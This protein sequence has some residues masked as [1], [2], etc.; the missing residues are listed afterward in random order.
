MENQELIKLG[1]RVMIKNEKNEWECATVENCNDATVL[2]VTDFGKIIEKSLN[3]VNGEFVK[4]MSIEVEEGSPDMA[5]MS[6]LNESTILTNLNTRYKKNEIYTYIGSILISVNP[7]K[8]IQSMYT[9]ECLASYKNKDLGD[10]PPHVFAIANECF[11]CMWKR[12]ENQCILISGESGAGKTETTKFMLRYLSSM[13]QLQQSTKKNLEP[14]EG[15]KKSIEASILESGPILE[16]L[17]NAKTVY[18]N[19]SSRFGKFI[20]LLFN[21]SGQIKGAQI[22]DYLL[23]KHRVVHQN[24]GERNYHIFYQIIRGLSEEEKEKFKLTEPENF[25][26]L[27]QSNCTSDPTLNDKKDW[28]ELDNALEVLGFK[29]GQREDFLSVLSGILY[30][31]NVEFVNAGGAQVVQIDVIEIASKLLGIEGERLEGVMKEKTIQLR[32][33]Y[34]TSPQS[35]EQAGAS[36][37]SISMALYSNLFRW[38]ISKINAKIKGPDNFHFIG[39]LDIFGFENFKVNRFEQ[40]CINFA[41]EKLQEYFNRH[42][43]S[44]EQI[45]YSREGIDWCEVEWMDNSECLDLVEK[46]LGLISLINEE[47]RFPKGTDASLLQKLH[48]QHKKNVFYVKP[49]VTGKEFGIKHYA[50]EVMYNVDGFLEKNRDTFRDDLLVLLKDSSC[51][52]IYE[53]FEK[54]RVESD[55][56]KGKGR[57]KQQPTAGG[58]FKKSLHSL[59]EQLST[60]NPFFVRCIKPNVEKLPELFKSDVVLNQLRYSGM[61]ETIRVR[62]AGFPVRRAYKD[63][64]DRYWMISTKGKVVENPENHCQEILNY[65]E[66]E[67]NLWRMGKTKAF[68]KEGIEKLLEKARGE[69]VYDAAVKVQSLIRC[70]YQ[71]KK[72]LNILKSNIVIQRIIRGFLARCMYKKVKKAVLTLQ[73]CERGRKARKLFK[74][75][76]EEKR[77]RERRRNN[78]AITIQKFTRGYAARKVFKVLLEKHRQL[79]ALK[80][81]MERERKEEAERRQKEEEEEAARLANKKEDEDLQDSSLILPEPPEF[82]LETPTEKLSDEI[83]ISEAT[84]L[85]LEEERENKIKIPPPPPVRFDSMSTKKNNVEILSENVSSSQ[86]RSSFEIKQEQQLAL[87]DLDAVIQQAETD[88]AYSTVKKSDEPG[89]TSGSLDSSTSNLRSQEQKEMERIIQLEKEIQEMHKQAE[90]RVDAVTQLQQTVPEPLIVSEITYEKPKEEEKD[91]ELMKDLGFEDFEK[92]M[93]SM[94]NEQTEQENIIEKV[95]EQDDMRSTDYHLGSSSQESDEHDGSDSYYTDS[96]FDNDSDLGSEITGSEVN[97][98]KFIPDVYFHSYIEMKGGLMNQWKR[99][100]CAISNNLFMV[101]RSKQDSLKCGWLYKKADQKERSGS[102][103][104]TLPRKNWQKKWFT[105]KSTE[106][107]YYDNDEENAKCRGAFSIKSFV[108]VSDV[109]EKENG[110]DIVMSNNKIMQVAAEN[111]EDSN[112]WYSILMKVH[113]SSDHEL[114]TMECDYANPKNALTTIEGTTIK[115]AANNPQAGKPNVFSITTSQRVYSF[116]CKMADEMHHWINL[117]NESRY[118][119]T[120]HTSDGNNSK[121]VHDSAIQQG[122]MIKVVYNKLKC[123]YQRRYF[124][125]KSNVIEYY[126]TADANSQKMGSFGLN[127]LCLVGTPDETIFKRTGKWEFTVYG[128]KHQLH[129]ASEKEEDAN[130]WSSEI[131]AVIDNTP[132][133]ITK[134]KQCLERIKCLKKDKEIDV[135]YKRHPIM[136]QTQVPLRSPLL[137]LSYE[138]VPTRDDHFTLRDEAVKFFAVL[139]SMEK[140]SYES[141]EHEAMALQDLLRVCHWSKSLQDEIFL[142]LIKQTAVFHVNLMS[143]DEVCEQ[144]HV[145][146]CPH[147]WHLMACMC[148]AYYP[149]RPVLA[150]LKFHLERVQSKYPESQAAMFAEYGEEA[151]ELQ[152][153][154][155]REQVPSIKEI[156]AI[157]QLRELTTK[158]SCLGGATCEISIRSSTTAG[159]VVRKLRRGMQLQ[160]NLNTFALFEHCNEIERAIEPNIYMADLIAKF[161]RENMLRGPNNEDWCFY[162]KLRCVF[163][164][165]NLTEDSI[166]YHFVFEEV[167]EQVIQG[168]FPASEDVLRE[169]AALRMQFTHGDYNLQSIENDFHKYYPVS[170][171]VHAYDL[172][173]KTREGTIGRSPRHISSPSRSLATIAESPRKRASIFNTFRRRGTKKVKESESQE[174]KM[175]LFREEMNDI[176]SNVAERWRKCKG[177]TPE[178]AV[179]DYVELARHWTGYGSSLFKVENNDS[180]FGDPILTL[181]VHTSGVSVYKRGHP[182]RLEEFSY[183]DILSFGAS[184]SNMGQFKLQ[185]EHRGELRF[186]TDDVTEIV[187]LM[188]SYVQALYRRKH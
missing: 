121:Q 80:E 38:V 178:D 62:K 14:N 23:E 5:R 107:C 118:I 137:P 104:G 105:L 131:Q 130:I 84:A 68:M 167:H 177:I 112:D 148:C 35:V 69:K 66:P 170:R 134:S 46:N 37:D 122:W 93:Q 53:L 59:M 144:Q 162:F 146:G 96:T 143:L 95:L 29:E 65:V 145:T 125:L 150:Y 184:E 141:V 116:S 114:Q 91:V 127:S 108:D 78:A 16:A 57:R 52:L 99:R 56:P 48:N 54:T 17:G 154:R 70:N 18:N 34:I 149:S 124:V 110:I 11:S 85:T 22:T 123:I 182:T 25:H 51:D 73:R 40:F 24:P 74:T 47:S 71:R 120:S 79:I 186:T 26:Y 98:E 180:Q 6:E 187:K 161:E 183:K 102:L 168:L 89:T 166:E 151:L 174:A 49:R 87:D 86:N 94:L 106:L 103:R 97:D 15:F 55:Q 4:A 175:T 45:E 72:Y 75:L 33:E 77:E 88:S 58:Q 10:R 82:V 165:I 31:G 12:E 30:L 43:F 172:A 157:L 135:F 100:W 128:R 155:R 138:Q 42:I 109:T 153:S 20:Q 185:V 90:A 7:Y 81:Q 129:I 64:W 179:R 50:G 8:R 83:S 152:P 27:N 176:Q 142:Q 173:A 169:L 76:L 113:S 164:P 21:E 92:E 160:Q 117:I 67:K 101:F 36:R 147:Y 158:I 139:I 188:R 115:Q 9:D 28:D 119:S 111:S 132:P 156:V 136:R 41:N 39:I 60:A 19:N 163:D 126:K 171:V 181:A 61:L 63:F 140:E 159:Q 32:G 2:L 3:S 13:S 1:A 44:L 133:I